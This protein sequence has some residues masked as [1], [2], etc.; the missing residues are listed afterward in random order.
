[1]SVEKRKWI[2][3]VSV[4]ALISFIF[5]SFIGI[6]KSSKMLQSK[7][8]VIR[9][10]PGLF[11][12]FI[13]SRFWITIDIWLMSSILLI[14]AA[15]S[16]SYYFISKRLEEK[17]EANL[18]IILKLVKKRNSASSKNSIKTD[19]KNIILKFLNFG[20]RKVVEKLIEKKGEILQSEITRLEGMTK[21]KTHRA[22]RNLE[23]KG[24]IKVE[25]Y[26]KTNRII[27][28]KDVREVVLK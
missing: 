12:P 9:G 27:L 6:Y 24:I 18:N 5:I 4:I 14:V 3:L 26:G 2:L 21:L 23:K 19:Y 17:L 20:E 25:K 28:S 16:T 1:M 11:E 8:L 10:S 7:Q 15:I 22:V 13:I